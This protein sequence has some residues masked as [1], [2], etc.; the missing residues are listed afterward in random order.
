MP[1]DE[2]WIC[3]PNKRRKDILFIFTNV[4]Q[5]LKFERTRVVC[6]TQMD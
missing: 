4:L 2:E 5:S 3:I 1:E 6:E